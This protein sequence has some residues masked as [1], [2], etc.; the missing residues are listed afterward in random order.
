MKKAQLILGLSLIIVFSSCKKG[1]DGIINSVTGAS[2]AIGQYVKYTIPQGEQYSDNSTYAST[3]YSEQKFIVKFDSSAIYTTKET[4]N[5]SDVNK[6]YGFS[7]NNAQHHE[8]SAR[9]GWR[10]RDNELHLFS[11]VYNNSVVAIS[12]L[13]KVEI[14]TE[15]TCSIKV[16][17]NA[18]IFTVNGNTQ[19]V[20]RASTTAT[21]AGYKLYPYFGGNEMAPHTITISIKEL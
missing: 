7:D 18:Y 15:N 9:I 3:S 8:F 16:S 10:W 19:S 5:Q 6:L 12:D 11:Y 2:K 21:A 1:I 13:G 20:P 4:S 14:G 17:G